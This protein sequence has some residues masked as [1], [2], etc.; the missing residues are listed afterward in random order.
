M[1]YPIYGQTMAKNAINNKRTYFIKQKANKY[2]YGE[3]A[4]ES[5]IRKNLPSKQKPDKI[6]KNAME[7][8]ESG[9]WVADNYICTY[10][11]SEVLEHA[12][13][14]QK[15]KML[16]C[17]MDGWISKN[18]RKAMKLILKSAQKDRK[19]FREVC[20]K[21]GG[22]DKLFKKLF[23][24]GCFGIKSYLVISDKNPSFDDAINFNYTR[25]NKKED[26]SL[27]FDLRFSETM[28]QAEKTL[29]SR[30]ETYIKKD[31]VDH[32]TSGD[33]KPNFAVNDKKNGNNC[34]ADFGDQK[35]DFVER[36]LT[37]GCFWIKVK[38]IKVTYKDNGQ[39]SY[40]ATMY[41]EEQTGVKKNNNESEDFLEPLCGKRI[42]NMGEWT[43]TGE[44]KK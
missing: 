40:R 16:K 9:D 10:V 36:Y 43:I 14:E 42:V 7:Y 34:G 6:L 29:K 18:D 33:K 25:K 41:I 35:Q 19:E 20:E 1:V 13:S 23:D 32:W 17:L 5:Y 37:I 4:S 30:I 8:Y 28:A 11:T 2:K 27:Y 15:S 38:D 22:S 3:Y 26:Y 24:N 44:G 31:I 21:A 12:N 39:F